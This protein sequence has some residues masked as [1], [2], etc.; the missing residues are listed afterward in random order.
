MTEFWE[1]AFAEKQ[2]MWGLE[3]TTSASLA[4]D[5]FARA[6]VKSVLIP[7]IGYGRNAKP[8]LE[9]GMSVAGIEISATAIELARSRL[10]LEI[11]IV[12]GSVTDMPFDR[13]Q[14][15]GIFCYGL[16]FLLDARGRE[17]L[18]RDCYRQLAPGGHMIFTIISKKA[19]MYGR[20]LRLGDDWYE[21]L[22][23]LPMYFYDA[24]S[25]K[26][27]FGPYGLVELSDIDEP[28][29]SGA[30]LPFINVV[31]R[32]DA[33]IVSADEA[34]RR[35][36]AGQV[37]VT[38]DGALGQTQ[39]EAIAKALETSKT[40]I[41][42]MGGCQITDLG[43]KAIGDALLANTALKELWLFN[44]EIGDVGGEALGDVLRKN[45]S[46]A[47]L[48]L[49]ENRV[50]DSGAKAIGEALRTSTSLVELGLGRNQIGDV[51]AAAI[52]EALASNSSVI[53]LSLNHNQICDIG[54]ARVGDA[55]RSNA[56]LKIL[57]LRNNAIGDVGAEAV[58][59]AIARN[60]TLRIVNFEENPAS[61]AFHAGIEAAL[62]GRRQ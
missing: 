46:L 22:P 52:G 2:L 40:T 41:L 21:R 18:I 16:V 57:R 9:R 28:A 3:P 35:L 62:E 27:E 1:T 23:G 7:G 14:Y 15:D 32:R 37:E 45:A 56:S 30:T 54:A 12:Q 31:C 48:C 5:T 34:V 39:V 58:R 55:L 20:G 8:F 51:G 47:T 36:H 60:T 61:P 4:R 25:V 33:V 29:G 53:A 19:P 6:G 43:C 26:R 38:V 59:T 24:E 49:N 44:N 42:R 17:K 10:G 13:R 50:G 11:P